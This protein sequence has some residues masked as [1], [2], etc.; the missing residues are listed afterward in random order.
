MKFENSIKEYE[1]NHIGISINDFYCI[2]KE[3]SE[4]YSLFYN[5]NEGYNYLSLMVYNNDINHR[6]RISPQDFRIYLI[7]ESDFID[8]KNKKNPIDINYIESYSSNFDE[9]ILQTTNF[10]LDYIEY[11]SDDGIIFEKINV[12][13]GIRLNRESQELYFKNDTNNTIL[14]RIKLQINR[15]TFDKYKRTYMKLQELL[16]E[17]ESIINL[18]FIIGEIIANVVAKKKMNLDL[19]RIIMN[20]KTELNKGDFNL[21]KNNNSFDE[22]FGNIE[23]VNIQNNKFPRSI[24]FDNYKYCYNYTS[25]DDNKNTNL[26]KTFNDDPKKEDKKIINE[27]IQKN[28]ENNIINEKKMK[29]IHIYNILIS[30]FCFKDKKT[31]LI[32]LCNNFI[33]NELSIDT[34]LFRLFKLEK[35]YYLLSERDKAKIHYMHIKELEGINDYLKKTYDNSTTTEERQ[36]I[37]TND[38]TI[39][40]KKNYK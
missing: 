3:D 39:T 8:H 35:I 26:F 27:I 32:D 23:D 40:N 15:N 30:Y 4:K 20:K 37:K 25:R 34:I 29:S 22:I 10:Y 36:I 11:D 19:T 21:Y 17:I 18:F 38:I 24:S 16:S 7:L 6:E 14:G 28:M 9:D 31:K 13:K 1:N 2:N 5:K 12:Y 33:Y